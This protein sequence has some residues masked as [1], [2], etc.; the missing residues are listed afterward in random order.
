MVR[1]EAQRKGLDFNLDASAGLP[2]VVDADGKRLRQILLNLLGNAIKFTDSGGVTL[3][4]D[5]VPVQDG[6]VELR[7]S[8]RD[9]GVGISAKDATRI[10]APF[11]QATH[12]QKQES[13]VGLGLA[14]TRELA[15]LMGGDVEVDSQPGGGSQ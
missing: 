4:V 14:I 10:F 11:E 5:C 9:T 7:V 1:V 12:G 3:G 15:R 2:D 13:G 6:K 8:V